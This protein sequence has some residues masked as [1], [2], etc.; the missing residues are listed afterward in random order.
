MH[1]SH[2]FFGFS[3]PHKKGEMFNFVNFIKN[4][5]CFL[6]KGIK[7]NDLQS[8]LSCITDLISPDKKSIISLGV[9]KKQLVKKTAFFVQV[10]F[11]FKKN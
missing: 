1:S 11:F 2:T 8:F 6:R 7:Q 4:E 9:L 10:F 3:H 5:K